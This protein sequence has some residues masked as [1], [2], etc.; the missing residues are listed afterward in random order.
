MRTWTILGDI[1]DTKQVTAV[2]K[3]TDR[4]SA[5]E[6]MNFQKFQNI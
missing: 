4:I 1:Y 3:K 5:I 2:K 6:S